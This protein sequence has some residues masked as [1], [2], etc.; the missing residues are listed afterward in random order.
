MRNE[1]NKKKKDLL[2]LNIVQSSVL[3][4]GVILSISVAFNLEV[5]VLSILLGVMIGGFMNSFVNI[6]IIQHH[7]DTLRF[8]HEIDTLVAKALDNHQARIEELEDK[9]KELEEGR[10]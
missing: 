3:G 10:Q 7:Q 2:D 6:L 9:I 1:E 4:I 5:T 8:R